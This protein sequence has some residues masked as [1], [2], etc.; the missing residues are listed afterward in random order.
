MACTAEQTPVHLACGYM[1]RD[2]SA[3]MSCDL[4]Q[5]APG[6]RNHELMKLTKQIFPFEG[7]MSLHLSTPAFHQSGR[8]AFHRRLRKKTIWSTYPAP[9]TWFK[10]TAPPCY[11]TSHQPLNLR[12][13]QDY[14]GT[15][16][17]ISLKMY[18]SGINPQT[19][20]IGIVPEHF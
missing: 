8:Q 20:H 16:K 9:T 2:N 1:A 6:T 10:A 4:P 11:I 15:I 14:Q 12:Q 13:Q 17:Q 19:L 18:P 7:P 5:S 3:C